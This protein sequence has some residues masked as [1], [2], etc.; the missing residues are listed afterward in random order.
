MANPTTLMFR[1]YE[2]DF[3][4]GNFLGGI[5]FMPYQIAI[6][7]SFRIWCTGPAFR[8]Y[9]GPFKFWLTYLNFSKEK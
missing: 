6:G 7:V 2:K 5:E 1:A 8:F 3:S 9:A 4:F